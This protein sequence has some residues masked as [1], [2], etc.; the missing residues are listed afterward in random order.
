MSGRKRAKSARPLETGQPM[1]L[2]FIENKQRENT[3]NDVSAD[4]E[5]DA[6][7]SVCCQCGKEGASAHHCMKCMRQCH[8]IQPC[9]FTNM[10]DE[11]ICATC[12][13]NASDNDEMRF[14]YVVY[15]HGYTL[16]P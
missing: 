9:G 16:L 14:A 13:S 10:E 12:N 4:F 8:A 7:S 11:T 1:L 2:Q 6:V 15:L 3:S 5:Q